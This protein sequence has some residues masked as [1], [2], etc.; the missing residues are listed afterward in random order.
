M[1]NKK[2][3]LL[4]LLL[5][6]VWS[7]AF[8][9]IKYCLLSFNPITITFCRVLISFIFFSILMSIKQ[10]PFYKYWRSWK[11]FFLVG[12]FANALPF[13]LI[14]TSEKYI[15]S[16]LA[17]LLNSS[18]PIFTCVLAHFFVPEEPFTTRR[19]LGVISGFIGIAVIF[20]PNSSIEEVSNFGITLML[21]ASVSYAIAMIISRKIS[22]KF[23]M[24]VLPTW[25]MLCAS[26]VMII[27]FLLFGRPWDNQ[28]PIFISSIFSLLTLGILATGVSFIL[29]YKIIKR[30]GAGFLSLSTL[31]FPVFGL[32]LGWIFLGEELHMWSYLGMALIAFG[33]ILNMRIPMQKKR[34]RRDSL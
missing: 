14:S 13:T 6:A 9:L 11:D 1:V 32:F 18:V 4:L 19:F 20:L 31:L 22:H 3:V 24:Y 16:A 30:A 26:A 5:S 27:P 12:F 8:L 17:A 34:A 25:Q 15:P 21:L 29:Y 10:I 2:N 7:P 33:L 28:E 23:P